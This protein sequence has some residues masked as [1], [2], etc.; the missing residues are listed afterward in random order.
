[1]AVTVVPSAQA[2]DV[3]PAVDD[4]NLR[5]IRAILEA[6]DDKIDLARAK[7]AIDHMID[8]ETDQ[9]AV[10][11]QI[12][13]MAAEIKASF[14]QGA[15]SLVKFKVLR[16]YLYRPPP[17]SG[18]K[19]FLY[20][21]EDDRNPKAKLLSVYLTTH[22]GNCVSM[23]L[24]FVILGQ[25]LGIPVT[26][27]TAPAHLYVKFRGDNGLWYGV[28]TTSG[29]GWAEDDW[30]MTQF[31]TL[32]QKAIAN[33]IYL[34]PLTKTETAA[35]IAESLFDSYESQHSNEADEAR[36]KLSLLMLDHYPKD[37][38]AMINAYMGYKGLRQRLFVDKYPNAFDIPTSLLPRYEQL[39]KGWWYWGNKVKE[40]GFQAPTASMEAA[41]RERI[42][43]ARAGEDQ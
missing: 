2:L 11:K 7:L 43:R 5:T 14:P 28:E 23:P 31:P 24:L 37:I 22:R 30:Q 15:S 27:T 8:P 39:A 13:N 40:L 32:T 6:P 4:A 18:R 41:Y 3:A 17:S 38:T 35:V 10:R 36:I 1:M 25:K 29:G 21:F 33:G 42:R 26:I 9:A 16:D 19:P 34:Q 20:N 12:D